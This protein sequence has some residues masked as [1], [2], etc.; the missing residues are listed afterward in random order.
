MS[1]IEKQISDVVSATS[2]LTRRHFIKGVAVAGLGASLFGLAACGS[3]DKSASTTSVG[4][5]TTVDPG[6]AQGGTLRVAGGKLAAA[7]TPF[8]TADE[9]SLQ[10]LCAVGEYLAWEDDKGELAPRVAE[11][12]SSDDGGQTWTYVIRQG[13]TFH[14]G[15]PLSANDVVWTISS[16]LNPDNASQSAGKF[17]GILEADGITKIDDNTVQFSLLGA[18]GSFP[19]ILSSTSYGLFIFKDGESGGE[20]WQTTMNGC[21]PWVLDKYTEGDRTT[22]TR[23]DNYWDPSRIPSF[24]ALEVIQFESAE[25]AVA[26]LVTGQIDAIVG[27]TPAVAA[28][29]DLSRADLVQ[30]ASSG[31]LA[32]HMR[33]DFGPFQDKRVRQAAALTLAR[34]DYVDGVLKGSGVVGNDSIMDAYATKDTSVPQREKDLVKA[35]A[36][37]AEAGVAD[38]FEVDLSSFARD[39]INLL[40]PFLQSSLAEIGIK[41][42]IKLADSY[43]SPPWTAQES[44]EVENHVWL[45]SN[46]GITNWGHRGSPV[47]ILTRA[48]K[49]T[50]DWNAA[51]YKSDAFDAAADVYISAT[52]DDARKAAS[53]SI[54]E[55]CLED[56]PYLFLYFGTQTAVVR[57]GLAGFYANGMQ[58][59]ESAAAHNV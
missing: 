59:F 30:V 18:V 3:D 6:V 43:Y 12:W 52:T 9:G 5:D 13:I 27:V 55:L 42:T 19:S 11:S 35:K 54:Q 26:Q 15:S 58:Q 39:D 36:L 32:V 56:T 33:N 28:T 53:K 44:K 45:E 24:D 25:S 51:H 14:D 2:G 50:G 31:H 34:Q 49:S 7:P 23:N 20:G 57:K 41:V 40:A 29:I 38:G 1:E 8:T 17:A 37:M 4:T 21:G 16:H 22:F 46:F 47:E 48:F 10:I